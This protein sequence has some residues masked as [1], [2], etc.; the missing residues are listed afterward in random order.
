MR[1]IFALTFLL[2]TS[3]FGQMTP[4]KSVTKVKQVA[5]ITTKA[6]NW[7]IGLGYGVSTNLANENS[8]RVY[9]NSLDAELS[10]SLGK[11]GNGEAGLSIGSGLLAYADGN[12]IRKQESN[13]IWNDIA[14]GFSYGQKV[15][16]S[17][18][19]V[20]AFTENLPTGYESQMEGY[21]SVIDSAASLAVP[22]FNGSLSVV[23]TIAFSAIINSYAESTST[24]ETNT[25]NVT[26]YSLGINYVIGAGFSIGAKGVVKSV[27]FMNNENQLRTS[28]SEFIRYKG[29]NWA[30]SLSYL[31]GNYDENEN[32]RF[33]YLD[34]TRRVFKF[35]VN[36]EI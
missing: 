21:K 14:I 22:F 26:V 32:Y 9:E 17:S 27:H 29:S 3:A 12:N 18:K 24:L 5:P 15:F 13:P 36:F 10:Y 11:I 7:S 2:T 1:L 31:L 8:N 4:Q 6:R 30:A 20:L 35:G 23:N 34:D 16:G 25:D 33:L 28:T 19:L